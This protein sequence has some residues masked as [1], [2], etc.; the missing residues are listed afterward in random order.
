M[1]GGSLY[2]R[3]PSIM[4][5]DLGLGPF[6]NNFFRF[7][8]SRLYLLSYLLISDVCVCV[9]VY[10]NGSFGSCVMCVYIQIAHL[11]CVCVC[12]QMA[13]LGV[14]LCVCVYTNG[15]FGSCVM[16]VYAYHSFGYMYVGYTHTYTH[17]H[18]YPRTGFVVWILKFS[19]Q[20]DRP[21]FSLALLS[22]IVACKNTLQM[23]WTESRN[24]AFI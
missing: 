23:G 16:C 19:G 22:C 4:S 9:C 2:P 12:I 3:G 6:C 20:S 24:S 21:F 5:Y 7:H 14:V 17:I 1:S 10:T 13:H 18:I 8:S 11:G 15:S